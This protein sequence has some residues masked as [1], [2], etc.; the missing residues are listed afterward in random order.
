LDGRGGFNSGSSVG[1]II[2]GVCLSVC[3]CSFHS[4]FF[5]IAAMLISVLF[6]LIYHTESEK[7]KKRKHCKNKEKRKEKG[8][9]TN[10]THSNNL[11]IIKHTQS[12]LRKG[13]VTAPQHTMMLFFLFKCLCSVCLTLAIKN[14]HTK[15]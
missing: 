14:T 15:L 7:E 4:L 11:L 9:T 3:L 10:G 13:G 8:T 12:F 1:E 5:L 6:Q 2:V